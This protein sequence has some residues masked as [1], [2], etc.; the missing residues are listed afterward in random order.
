MG[1]I[2][3]E[4]RKFPSFSRKEEE[5]GGWAELLVVFARWF[6]MLQERE[7]E[8]SKRRLERHLGE[9]EEFVVEEEEEEEEERVSI[10]FLGV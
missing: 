7:R 6:V 1:G 9:L 2:W 4:I 3:F 5:R 8:N 10:L